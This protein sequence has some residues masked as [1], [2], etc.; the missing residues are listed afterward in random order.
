MTLSRELDLVQDLVLSMPSGMWYGEQKFELPCPREWDVTVARPNTPREMTAAEIALVLGQPVGQ[1]PLSVLARGSKTAAIIIDDVNRATPVSAVLPSVIRQLGEAGI[2]SDRITIV[3][4]CGAHALPRMNS[5]RSKVGEIASECTIRL[6]DANRDVARIGRTSFGTPV[7]LNKEVANSDFVIGIGGLYPNSTA[8]Y[9]GGS[10]LILG[11]LGFRSILSLHYLHGGAGRGLSREQDTFRRDLNEIA[12]LAR[13]RSLISVHVNAECKIVRMKCGDHLSYY[14]GERSF[15]QQAYCVPPP[16]DADV[17][18]SNAYPN[19]LS[20]TFALM[21]GAAPL[22]SC[23][24][25]SSRI[26]LARCSEGIGG[27]GLFP[28]VNV[29]RFHRSKMYLRF[30]AARPGPFFEKALRTA[31]KRCQRKTV[32][33]PGASASWKNPVHLYAGPDGGRRLSVGVPGVKIAD[34]WADIVSAV[35]R[36]QASVGRTLKV[37]V[38]PCAPLLVFA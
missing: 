36:E 25:S 5:V 22:H 20:L 19:D 38:Y 18:I 23:E 32:A 16:G 35:G 2:S 17:V 27:H 21:K 15:A 37:A 6:H 28:V 13:L 4:A 31:A 34:S 30:A 1:P 10:K 11:V 8:G 24:R 3:L 26:L 14:E 9:G 33:I 29:D 7:L 12:E